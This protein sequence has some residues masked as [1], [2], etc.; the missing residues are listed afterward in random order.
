MENA[1]IVL[2]HLRFG[3]VGKL[4]KRVRRSNARRSVRAD[5]KLTAFMELGVG[6]SV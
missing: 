5:E 2:I 6:D 4:L 3:S 1:P